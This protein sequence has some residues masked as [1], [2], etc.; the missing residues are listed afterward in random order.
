LC[1]FEEYMLDLKENSIKPFMKFYPNLENNQTKAIGLI[2]SQYSKKKQ[3][4]MGIGLLRR[5]TKG[6][7][8]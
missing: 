3:K 5:K 7:I 8:Y 4:K 1:A 2:R 6:T